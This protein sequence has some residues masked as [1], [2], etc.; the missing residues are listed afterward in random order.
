MAACRRNARAWIVTLDDVVRED[1]G[2]SAVAVDGNGDVVAIGVLHSPRPAEF[3][4][5]A[6]K[7][8]GSSGAER[9]RYI[10]SA[11]GLGAVA[12]D[13]RGDVVAAGG[14]SHVGAAVV[15][16]SGTSGAEI[17]RVVLPEGGGVDALAIDPTGE[18]IAVGS[19]TAPTTTAFTLVKLA[20]DDGEERWRR[21]LRP[22]RAFPFDAA[23][24]VALDRHGN[25]LAAGRTARNPARLGS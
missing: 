15:K 1:D 14:I 17:W 20:G 12:V 18:V 3:D 10:L 7:L 23:L 9:W 5:F 11:G 6:I 25:V 2:A 8:S 13:G 19:L 4:A 16:L 24:A 22:S 21:Q